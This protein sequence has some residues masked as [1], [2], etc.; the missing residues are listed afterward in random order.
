M[1]TW[2]TTGEVGWYVRVECTGFATITFDEQTRE[3]LTNFGSGSALSVSRDGNYKMSHWSGGELVFTSDGAAV[4]HPRP[5]DHHDDDD[6]EEEGKGRG[7]EE[8]TLTGGE[9]DAPHEECAYVLRH[10]APVAFE[11]IDTDGNLF[12]IRNTGHISMFTCHQ[13]QQDDEEGESGDESAG[14]SASKQQQRDPRQAY[15]SKYRRHPPRLFVVS[16]DGSGC[17]LLRDADL[18]DYIISSENDPLTAVIREAMIGNS[19]AVGQFA[20]SST[21]SC[22]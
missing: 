7:E 3:S 8:V 5:H 21:L 17:E 15:I 12:Q 14:A 22:A 10:N 2:V 13:Q 1:S 16:K 4:Y 20:L 19:G 18:R 6:C 9:M 11:T